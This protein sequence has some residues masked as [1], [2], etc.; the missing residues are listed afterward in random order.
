MRRVVTSYV[1]PDTDGVACALA[2]AALRARD[3]VGW[4]AAFVGRLNAETLAALDVLQLPPP[5]IVESL[6]DAEE[7][8]IV[9]THHLAQVAKAGVRPEIVV[10]IIDHH[11]NGD[12]TAFPRA[13]IDN[14]RVGAASTLLIER[15]LAQL[16]VPLL[17]LLAAGIVSNTLNF[18]APSTTLRDRDAFASVVAVEPLPDG[19]V[20]AME[21]ARSQFL[22]QPSY[23]VIAQDVKVFET[24]TGSLV[25]SQVEAP[26]AASLVERSDFEGAASALCRDFRTRS[27]VINLADTQ[28][29][30]SRVWASSAELLRTIPGVAPLD[31]PTTEGPVTAWAER[32]LL[33]KTDL[34]PYLVR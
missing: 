10:E 32:L 27:C 1:N 14:Q 7:I 26:G 15:G 21:E 31:Q 18:E 6:T 20:A 3:D 24:P 23:D 19:L 22:C 25:L 34:V 9:D 16:P 4:T 17:H 11:T 12:P 2:Y 5:P 28:V 13:Q 29:G 33:R 8:A 30:A